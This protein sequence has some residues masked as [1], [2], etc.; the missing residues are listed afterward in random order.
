MDPLSFKAMGDADAVGL[1]Y[2][3]TAGGESRTVYP[4]TKLVDDQFQE[5]RTIIMNWKSDENAFW[6]AR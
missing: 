6:S 5:G 1:K 3:R 4:Q 2:G